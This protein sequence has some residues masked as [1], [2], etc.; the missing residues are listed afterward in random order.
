MKGSYA[1]DLIGIVHYLKFPQLV[2]QMPTQQQQ[3]FQLFC[4]PSTQDLNEIQK[5]SHSPIVKVGRPLDQ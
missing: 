4:L 3:K 2:R 1:T 5:T